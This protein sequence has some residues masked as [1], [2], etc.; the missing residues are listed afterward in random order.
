[1]IGETPPSVSQSSQSALITDVTSHRR[2]PHCFYLLYQFNMAALEIF[3]T[4]IDKIRAASTFEKRLEV[5][6]AGR[7][8]PPILKESDNAGM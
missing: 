8:T 3:D 6:Q 7:P 4:V 5:K 2:N 1:M